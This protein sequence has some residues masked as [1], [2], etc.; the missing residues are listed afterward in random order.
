MSEPDIEQPAVEAAGVDKSFGR[1]SVLLR[2]EMN[3][4]AGRV[5]T[6]FGPNGSGKTTLLRILAGLTR[7]DAGSISVNGFDIAR[8]AAAARASTGAVMHAPL[9]YMDLTGREN[10]LFHARM[11]RVD[12]AVERLEEV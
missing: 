3:V 2:L 8:Q 5:F 7:V 4:T 12:G 6:V 1:A 11:F 9:L 10:L